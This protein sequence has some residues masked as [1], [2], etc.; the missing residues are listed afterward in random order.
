MSEPADWRQG[1]PP[2]V[3][4][5]LE[6]IVG[7]F[8]ASQMEVG[9]S[10]EHGELGYLYAE[11]QLLVREQQVAAV[12]E[13]L[14]QPARPELADRI[15]PGVVR[16]HLTGTADGSPA[17]AV[18]T[19]L[20][21]IDEQIGKGNA[22]PDH[23][24]TVAPIGGVCPAT[25]PEEVTPDIEPFPSLHTGSD[26]AGVFVYV[27]DTGLLADAPA[28]HPW[29]AGVTGDLDPLPPCDADGTQPIPPYSG[30]GTF[31]AGV[32]R[33][34]APAAQVYVGK[35]FK[36]AGS[37]LESDLV[38]DL[39]RALGLGVDIFN[40]SIATTTRQDLP[41]LAFGEFLRHLSSYKGV[42]CTVAAGNE[43]SRRPTWP[44]A[45][46]GMVSVGALTRD[47]AA[48]AQFSNRGG[49]V[50]VYAPGRDHVNAYATGTYTCHEHPLTGQQRKFYGMALWSGTSF[51]TPVVTGLIA[52]RMSRTGGNG[53][54]AAQAL[55]A[56]A[57]SRAIPGI[58]AV[59][60]PG[61]HLR[62]AA[63]ET[64]DEMTMTFPAE[65]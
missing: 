52:A 30:H 63:D 24:V 25:E 14:A 26:G 50:D 45:L 8:S 39:D 28:T 57:R 62:N 32:I 31:V 41:L 15:T 11:G 22:T 13:I 18:A 47:G 53:Q 36:T 59:L 44:A 7:A 48:M 17:P 58:G 27:A 42:V 20:D 35:V 33:S 38:L 23:V 29:L 43:S 1:L 61:H 16:L 55:L 54:Q 46:P 37:A 56:E 49:W 60:M 2:K 6:H 51:S 21:Q 4:D 19:A 5:Q 65:E 9:V 10:A 3:V 34:I 12:R 40:L 64:K